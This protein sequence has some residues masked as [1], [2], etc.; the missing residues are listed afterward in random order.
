MNQMT[1]ETTKVLKWNEPGG[2]YT[3]TEISELEIHQ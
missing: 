2:N 3:D 1:Q